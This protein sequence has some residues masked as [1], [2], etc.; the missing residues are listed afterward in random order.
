MAYFDDQVK[1][2]YKHR[3]DQLDQVT[4]PL[5]NLVWV[6]AL[7]LAAWVQFLGPGLTS[8]LRELSGS[9][10]LYAKMVEGF[11]TTN[12]RL[13][14]MESNLAPP[15]V[16]NWNFDRQVG[17]CTH[18]E[19]RVLHN[20]SRTKYGEACGVPSSRAVIRDGT[21]GDLFDLPFA[22]EFESGD[23]TRAGRNFIVP[24]VIPDVVQPGT[25][26]YQFLNIYPTC[27]WTREP[28]PRQSPWF[29]LEVK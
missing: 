27:E 23:A 18:S 13:D 15:R 21:T 25:H 20:I 26:Q 28:I 9:N 3:A 8:A 19:C 17:A 12:E 29:S 6:G 4:K 16:A 5:R 11:D 2:K 14:F 7:A 10:A 1:D 22:S 24:F